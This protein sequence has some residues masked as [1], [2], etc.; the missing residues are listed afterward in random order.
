MRKSIALVTLGVLGTIFVFGGAAYVNAQAAKPEKGVIVGLA[1]EISTYVMKGPEADGFSETCT[2]RSEQDFPVA[3][4]EEETGDVYFCIY[5]D[6]APASHTVKAN[7]ILTEYM[8]QKV[9]V[10]GLKYKRNGINLIRVS[11]I[12]EY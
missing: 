9:V 7:K 1:V 6:P 3:I 4:I 10:Q 11:V 8:G 5:R 12:S 2:S